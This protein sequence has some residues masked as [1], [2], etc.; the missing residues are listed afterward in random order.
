MTR[1]PT[2]VINKQHLCLDRETRSVGFYSV[3]SLGLSFTLPLGLVICP[4]RDYFSTGL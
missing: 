1:K 2:D 4:Y 3:Q